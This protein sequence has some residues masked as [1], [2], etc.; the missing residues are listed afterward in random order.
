ME[1]DTLQAASSTL[2]GVEM[3][4]VVPCAYVQLRASR[5]TSRERKVLALVPG[6]SLKPGARRSPGGDAKTIGTHIGEILITLGL[7]EREGEDRRVAAALAH[8]RT[9]QPDRIWLSTRS[10]DPARCVRCGCPSAT[11]ELS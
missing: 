3:R 9:S 11:R 7:R 10:T 1:P 2:L 8:L 4:I 6:A 5:R